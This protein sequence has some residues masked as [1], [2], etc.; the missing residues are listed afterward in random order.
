MV[1]PPWWSGAGAVV[2]V[3][4]SLRPTA[5]PPHEAARFRPGPEPGQGSAAA[6]AA[7]DRLR[8]G[9]GD[10]QPVTT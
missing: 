1:R 5:W 7:A 4:A 9:G 6:A 3:L 2:R 10:A 8:R